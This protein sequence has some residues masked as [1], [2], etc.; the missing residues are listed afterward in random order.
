MFIF[1]RRTLLSAAGCTR[2]LSC[3]RPSSVLSFI[4]FGTTHLHRPAL[5]NLNTST[6]PGTEASLARVTIPLSPSSRNGHT[7]ETFGVV[8]RSEIGELDGAGG[9]RANAEP[10]P[11]D[12]VGRAL[13]QVKQTG[14]TGDRQIQCTVSGTGHA[15]ELRSVRDAGLML[16]DG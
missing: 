3:S 4:G 15:R 13:K 7:I 12:Q 1:L 16:H 8:R 14:V 5:P 6:A 11:I 2:R 10:T 9:I